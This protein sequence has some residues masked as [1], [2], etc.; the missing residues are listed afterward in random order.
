MSHFSKE[1]SNVFQHARPFQN[2]SRNLNDCCVSSF[3]KGHR[4][5]CCPSVPWGRPLIVV[6]VHRWQWKELQLL[7]SQQSPNL[8]LYGLLKRPRWLREYF[9]DT[10]VWER[11]STQSDSKARVYDGGPDD[12]DGLLLLAI[13][14]L[15]RLTEFRGH[16]GAVKA[17]RSVNTCA[18]PYSHTYREEGIKRNSQNLS[19]EEH[20]LL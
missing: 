4:W 14:L 19:S 8:P 3:R 9:F 17:C 6:V 11:A 13:L 15:T 10:G 7:L 1:K 20:L 2:K 12:D 16:P 5:Q 18:Q